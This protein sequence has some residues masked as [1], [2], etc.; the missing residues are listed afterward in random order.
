MKKKFF[1]SIEFLFSTEKAQQDSSLL[2]GRFLPE[3]ALIGRS[4]VGK[5]SLINHLFQNKRLAKVSSTPG[6]TKL[7]NY[8]LVDDAYYLI[9]LPGYGYA[10]TNK[11]IQENWASFIDAYLQNNSYLKLLLQLVD[12]RHLP[13][14]QDLAFYQ[15]AL[16]HKLPLMLVLTKTDKLK[17]SQISSQT[18]Q[19][20]TCFEKQGFLYEH[21]TYS[22]Y[23][24]LSK[25]RLKKA[26]H[27][28]LNE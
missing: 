19:I 1:S 9:D 5:S 3:I 12:S 26:I 21:I 28:H 4:N 10:K 25:D 2:K 7:L 24:T 11:Q 18:K 16:F 13:S 14:T 23:D 15:W 8:F 20:L 6:K 27:K 17:K 22:I